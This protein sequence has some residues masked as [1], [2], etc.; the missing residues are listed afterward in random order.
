ME[1]SHT[2][3]LNFMI[4][5]KKIPDIISCYHSCDR[6][7][8]DEEIIPTLLGNLYYNNVGIRSPNWRP[9]TL[10]NYDEYSYSFFYNELNSLLRRAAKSNNLESFIV[11]D[12]IIMSPNYDTIL[13][14]T[15]GTKYG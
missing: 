6:S 8:D 5:S 13:L 11:I 1:N 2:S 14:K 12:Y 4:C 3:R 15:L 7:L 10:N 9:E